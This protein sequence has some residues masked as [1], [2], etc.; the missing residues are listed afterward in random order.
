MS[1][2]IGAG[3]SW[4]R[5]A[6][7]AVLPL[8]L[9]L[10][11]LAVSPAAAQQ[12]NS[13]NQWVAPHGVGTF[14][15]SLGQEYS[16]VMA[17]AALLPETEFN[18]GFT[19]FEESPED[20]SA[21]HYS[22]IFYVKRRLR[23]NAAGN[24]G[25]AVTGGTGVNP[26]FLQQGEVTDTFRSW[27]ANAVY[28][29][30]FADGAVAWDLLPGFLVNLDKDQSGQTAWGMTWSSR[31]AVYKIIP[32][33]AIVG[34]VFGTTGEAYAEPTYRIGVRWES[35]RVIIAGS[36]GDTFSGSGSPRFELG[37]IILTKQHKFL[38][39]G[40]CREAPDR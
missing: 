21:A 6:G 40:K 7:S 36:Y 4:K 17:V 3:R 27:W 33:S 37:V 18:L 20:Q 29:V 15:L 28:T 38:C 23:E 1:E 9:A 19:R 39:L 10:V 26:S 11:S 2:K 35:P 30:P 16:T 13:D 8:C 31:V 22:G 5:R 34:E 12:F 14:I 25:W 32:K 24:G